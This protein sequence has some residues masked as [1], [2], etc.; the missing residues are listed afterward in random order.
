M[1]RKLLLLF[2]LFFVGQVFSQ[3][4]ARQ[5]NEEILHAIR[6]DYARPTVHARNLFHSSVIMYD[7]WAVFDE[8]ADTYFLGKNVGGF[9]CDFEGFNPNEP[10][11]EARKKAISYGIYRLILHRFANSPEREEIMQSIDERMDAL[12]YDKN[13]SDTN[14]HNGNP[15]A[16]GN[17]LAQKMIEFGLQDGSNEANSYANQFYEPLNEPL[18]MD[19]SGNPDIEF[20]NNWQPL[21]IEAYVDQSGHTIPGGQPPFLGPEWG[22]VTPFSLSE[23]DKTVYSVPGYDYSVYH[24]PGPP[25]Y[26]QNGLGIDDAYKWHFALVAAWGAHLDPSD[27]VMI[28]ISPKSLGNLNMDEYPKTLS[29]YKEFYDLE[30]GGDPSRGREMNPIT[31]EP[32]QPNMVYRGDYARGLAEFWADGPDSETPPGHWF[33]LLNHIS[34][35][36]LTIKKFKGSGQVLS[37]LEWDVKSYFILGGAM[38]DVAVASWGVKGYY[39]FVRPV[40]AI[41]YMGDSGQSS[42][43]NDLSYDPHGLPLIPGRIEVVREGDSLAGNFNENVGKIKLYT[44]RGP[45]Y[46]VNPSIDEAG[47]GWILSA[48][49]WPYQRP[50]FVTPPFAG[51]VSGHSTFSRAAAEVLTQF[52]GSEYFPGGMGTFDIEQNE[53][54]VFEEGPSESFQIQW[55]TYRDASDQ[56]SLSRIWG[57]IHPPIDDIPGR[58]MGRK[59]GIEAFSFGEKYF[60][61]QIAEEGIIFPNPADDH[62]T[63]LYKAEEPLE[64]GIFDV[65]GRLILFKKADFDEMNRMSL[66]VSALSQ[67][68]YFVDLFAGRNKVWTSKMLKN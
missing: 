2:L 25:S 38:H 42:D 9:D 67:G 20:P 30:N 34:D 32:Y 16:L 3:S 26:I 14:Y 23:E 24:D 48:E 29:E 21:K 6:N 45:E 41:R 43:P 51:Y 59:V 7:L 54:L 15:A 11:I 18:N 63:I 4:V 52:T 66:N 53:F 50:S 46:I 33:V 22:G 13:F 40:S 27:G 47:V 57:G 17:Y 64:L 39:D 28:D 68:L 19:I 12:G 58:R 1:H 62:I 31:G 8:N 65:R 5:W 61:G 37:D 44:W 35:H 55:A 60:S 56:C 49:W 36:P 10:I